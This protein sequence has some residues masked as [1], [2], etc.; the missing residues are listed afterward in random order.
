M[1]LLLT[2]QTT[3]YRQDSPTELYV[4]DILID[5]A[6]PAPKPSWYDVDADD[7]APY[8]A[9]PIGVNDIIADD[10]N[11]MERLDDLIDFA[12]ASIDN[13]HHDVDVEKAP[14]SK[15]R[16]V[17][18]PIT[19]TQKPKVVDIIPEKS[20]PIKKRKI[21][22]RMSKSTSKSTTTEFSPVG[23]T[24][25]PVDNLYDI[26][27]EGLIN[28]AHHIIRRDVWRIS[29]ATK[30]HRFAREGTIVLG[31]RFCEHLPT[32]ERVNQSEVAPISVEGIYRSYLRFT[33]KH[34]KDC[35]FIPDRLRAKHARLRKAKG[36]ARGS[37]VYWTTSARNKGL[38][39][40]EGDKGIVFCEV[41][42][43]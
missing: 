8:V 40:V 36:G 25:S 16:K 42:N 19:I 14:E 12:A 26:R 7:R 31:C 13:K 17:H 27:D 1:K 35:T 37:K 39:N 22:H 38:D 15:K 43:Y 24:P 33:A 9:S 21:R 6:S 3:A 29:I 23:T 11:T 32:S 20:K 4:A 30:D 2:S 5:M 10:D 28:D 41:A 18:P 34:F